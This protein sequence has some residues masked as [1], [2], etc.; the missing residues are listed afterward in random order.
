MKAVI[1]GHNAIAAHMIKVGADVNIS[2]EVLLTSSHHAS[3]RHL[4][5]DGFTA[6]FWAAYD[7]NQEAT[8]LLLANGANFNVH[9]KVCS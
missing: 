5:Q 6:I 3:I 2:N 8:D 9:T 4:V 1:M 7:H